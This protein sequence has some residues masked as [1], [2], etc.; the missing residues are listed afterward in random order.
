MSFMA[1]R[2]APWVRSSSFIRLTTWRKSTPSLMWLLVSDITFLTTLCRGSVL[3]QM[4]IL[5][6]VGKRSSLINLMRASP[7]IPSLGLAQVRHLSGSGMG[8]LYVPFSNTSN[9][10]SRSSKTLRKRSHAICSMRWA[11]PDTLWSLRIMSRIFLMKASVI[12]LW[13]YLC[14]GI[15]QIIEGKEELLLPAKPTDDLKGEAKIGDGRS[16]ERFNLIN[17]DIAK[18]GILGEE[19]LDDF[20]SFALILVEIVG[21]AQSRDALG[22]FHHLL[23]VGH[24][25]DE[26]EEVK[27]GANVLLQFL[28]R[29]AALVEFVDDSLATLGRLPRGEEGLKRRI[30]VENIALGE[31]LERLG[32]E[33]AV[34][35]EVLHLLFDNGIGHTT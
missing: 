12:I 31:V 15:A 11:S 33:L 7:V 32:H 20:A 23:I 14:E 27:L 4:G 29:D 34:S 5:A 22:L 21:A 13:V 1:W 30:V 3:S 26:V 28:Q 2:S 18:I 6:S 17:G 10:F 25:H 19:G 16:L 9:S 24:M 8:D 35:T